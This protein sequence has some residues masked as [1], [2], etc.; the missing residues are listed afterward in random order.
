MWNWLTGVLRGYMSILLRHRPITNVM[1]K[2]KV[3]CVTYGAFRWVGLRG[4]CCHM[5]PLPVFAESWSEWSDWSECDASGV[6]VRARQCILLF[7]VGSQCSGNTT[8]SRP[9]GFDSNYIPGTGREACQC[10]PNHFHHLERKWVFGG[11]FICP[12][13]SCLRKQSWFS[14]PLRFQ[15]N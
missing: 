3:M 13:R 2:L 11:S 5:S 8:E 1:W 4:H 15:G 6:Q 12:W 9:C 14:Q 7:P 10:G